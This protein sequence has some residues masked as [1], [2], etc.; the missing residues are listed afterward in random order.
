MR[1]AA[2]VLKGLA[3]FKPMPLGAGGYV[4]DIQI[5][6]D[7]AMVCQTDVHGGYLKPAG[8]TKWVQLYN[9]TSFPGSDVGWNKPNNAAYADGDGVTI[10]I[11]PSNSAV[12]YMTQNGYWWR[13]ANS[14]ASFSKLGGG[15]VFVT[16]ANSGN[17]RCFPSRACV[18][19]QNA[20]VAMLGTWEGKVVYTIDGSTLNT[21]TVAAGTQLGGVNVPHL[22]TVDPSSSVVSSIKQKWAYSVEGTGIYE[23]T[24]GPGGAYSLLTGSPTSI[25]SLRY[26]ATGNL[27]ALKQG[28]IT[29]G[30]IYKKTPAGSFAK[31]TH[32]N[33]GAEYH[34]FA[35]DP[36][37]TN[38]V[39]VI[40]QDGYCTHSSDGGATWLPMFFLGTQAVPQ[41]STFSTSILWMGK[42]RANPVGSMGG[43]RFHPTNGK[44]YASTGFGVSW[45][46]P[47]TTYVDWQWYEDSLGLEELET[48]HIVVPPGGNPII[49][50]RDKAFFTITDENNWRNA[51]NVPNGTL[52]CTAWSAD[53]AYGAP[54]FIVGA[55]SF[56][57][58]GDPN[59]YSTD[60]GKTW[61]AFAGMH[62]AGSVY[63][64]SMVA[65]STTH[66]LWFPANNARAVESTDG[67]AT[68]SYIA[69]F[70]AGTG[71]E[72]GFGFSLWNLMRPACVD[73]TN[74][75]LYCYNYGPTGNAA[76]RGV[77]RLRAGVW[78][79]V[80]SGY[81]GGY[82]ATTNS[83]IQDVFGQT[84]HLFYYGDFNTPLLRSINGGVTWT[85][86]SGTANVTAVGFGKAAPGQTY[87]AVYL[88]S[89]TGVD[90]SYDNC[91]TWIH[92]ADY[93]G[94]SA[95]GIGCISG[96]PD[97][98]GRF[99]MGFGHR[100]GMI[101]NY[102]FKLTVS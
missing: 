68:W 13:S 47:P 58:E 21:L 62:P 90:V 65:L 14:G 96:H 77:W 64:G 19:P 34:A 59:G 46:I 82:T 71:G 18:D 101:G 83:H 45:S 67:G 100:G 92:L 78:T 7:G 39:V 27:W 72:T 4:T 43:L 25:R 36:S 55:C 98:F 50:V 37:N 93:P 42:T 16:Y 40:T 70:A 20:N 33:I 6:N 95:D 28:E 5:A 12:I 80:L 35:I 8:A 66:F 48:D 60:Y 57:S 91:V 53:Y 31:V 79:Q 99:Y 23:S 22:V 17:Q 87:P 52:Q 1:N 85:T 76:I 88:A 29:G 86:V 32:A 49:C 2:G 89:Q 97:I 63:G 26:D 69:T 73:K 51:S 74:G 10:T 24:T 41:Q 84:G 81:P 102:D 75:D 54:N 15:A 38:S 94:G 61:H 30:N 3:T 9:A 11:A 56:P 44:L